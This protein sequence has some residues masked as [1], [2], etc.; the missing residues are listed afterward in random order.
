MCKTDMAAVW[1]AVLV[2]I[3][4]AA[5]IGAITF[6]AVPEGNRTWVDTILG[7][8][9]G[10]VVSTATGYMIGSSKSSSDKTRNPAP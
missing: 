2:T 6:G 10:T 8:V 7:F 4:G 1:Y 3:L 5:Y 9:L